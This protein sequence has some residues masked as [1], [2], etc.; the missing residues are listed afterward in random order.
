HVEEDTGC[1]PWEIPRLRRFTDCLIEKYDDGVDTLLVGHSIGGVLACAIAAS[2]KESEV[3]G[4]V[5]IFSPHRFL[6]G[7]FSRLLAGL[8]DFDAQLCRSAP[9]GT[10]LFGGAHGIRDPWPILTCPRITLPILF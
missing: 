8:E 7:I 3:V 9:Q 5:T 10:S 1:H 4:V 6:G 2:C